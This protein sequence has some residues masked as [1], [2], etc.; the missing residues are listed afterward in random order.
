MDLAI[1]NVCKIHYAIIFFSLANNSREL[2]SSFRCTILYVAII[3]T[4]LVL[5]QCTSTGSTNYN[6]NDSG[7]SFEFERVGATWSVK[8][9]YPSL[10][11]VEGEPD[12][13]WN[14]RGVLSFHGLYPYP[15]LLFPT[16]TYF[17]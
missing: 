3:M 4:F 17:K 9:L 16:V 10:Y 15:Q 6:F 12:K 5:L 2:C 1:K 11:I 7:A 13:S 8:F 14:D